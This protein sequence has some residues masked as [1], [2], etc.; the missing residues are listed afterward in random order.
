MYNKIFYLIK[1]KIKNDLTT[2]IMICFLLIFPIHLLATYLENIVNLYLIND[3]SNIIKIFNNKEKISYLDVNFILFDNI[4][5]FFVLFISTIV[6]VYQQRK[7]NY[8]GGFYF[9]CI[10]FLVIGAIFNFKFT[11]SFELHNRPG[12]FFIFPIF[13]V[14]FIWKINKGNYISSIIFIFIIMFCC[15]F[16]KINMEV[17]SG[18]LIYGYIII[19]SYSYIIIK[20]YR[21]IDKVKFIKIKKSESIIEKKYDKN[22][23]IFTLITLFFLLIATC[24]TLNMYKNFLHQIFIWMEYEF[25]HN[26]AP[27]KKILLQHVFIN[28]S[29]IQTIFIM[30]LNN[31]KYFIVYFFIIFAFML[32]SSFIISLNLFKKYLDPFCLLWSAYIIL[33]LN[34]QYLIIGLCPLLFVNFLLRF[35]A[36][37]KYKLRNHIYDC[38]ILL[39]LY[40]VISNYHTLNKI[41][42]SYLLK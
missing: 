20:L 22:D 14:L 5:T 42:I 2:K 17:I 4:K 12:L 39:T 31:Y 6:L 35:N 7:I 9:L 1:D 29:E 25:V 8:K 41:F 33:F 18:G 37:K 26:I 38:I 32:L 34:N 23:Y 40:L 3:D 15:L 19:K 11:N 28:Q 21:Y 10:T 30:F 27:I 36:I 16:M 13:F 24:L